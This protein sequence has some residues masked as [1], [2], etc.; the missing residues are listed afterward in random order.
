MKLREKQNYIFQT[1]VYILVLRIKYR[2]KIFIHGLVHLY[3]Y[4]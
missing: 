4:F 2:V 3:K 1:F